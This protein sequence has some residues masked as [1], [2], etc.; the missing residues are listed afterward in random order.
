MP[1]IRKLTGDNQTSHFGDCLL[2]SHVALNA[3]LEVR[4]VPD[5]LSVIEDAASSRPK[6]FVH[7]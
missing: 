1:V 4:I 7:N 6:R 3:G 2:N 5:F